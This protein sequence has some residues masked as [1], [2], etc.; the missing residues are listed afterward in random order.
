M[1]PSSIG[2]VTELPKTLKLAL[3]YLLK[4]AEALK[5]RFGSALHKEIDIH[6]IVMIPGIA[7][8]KP[9]PVSVKNLAIIIEER[10][11]E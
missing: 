5:I 9:I 8:R 7:G 10:A 11:K 6:E 1:P 4:H 2:E 3:M